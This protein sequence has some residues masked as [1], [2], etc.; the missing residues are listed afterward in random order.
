[1]TTTKADTDGFVRREIRPATTDDALE[2]SQLIRGLGFFRRLAD[3][4]AETTAER[5]ERHLGMCLVDDSHTVLVA[6]DAAGAIVGYTAV[7]WLPYL[8]LGGPEGHVSELFIAEAVRGEGIGTAL[9]DAVVAE[10]RDRGCA[11]LLL[12]A[13]TSRESYLRG[14]YP[15]RGWTER[16]DMREFVLEL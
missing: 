3:E 15:K 14:F 9:L 7:H 5:V 2:L 6:T 1:M 12:A 16:A 13:V 10:A 11:R 4:D 8:F